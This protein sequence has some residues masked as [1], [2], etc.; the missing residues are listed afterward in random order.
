MLGRKVLYELHC[1][2]LFSQT[3]VVHE[4]VVQHGRR[5]CS[6]KIVFSHTDIGR[7]T[8]ETALVSNMK[9][10]AHQQVEILQIQTG[11]VV[12][13]SERRATASLGWI[14]QAERINQR[15]E[16]IKLQ[17]SDANYMDLRHHHQSPQDVEALLL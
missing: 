8:F 12:Q 11:N 7:H 1:F 4:K 13:A 14:G 9:R 6:W 10:R 15:A 5:D 16:N 17:L 2:G 3:H